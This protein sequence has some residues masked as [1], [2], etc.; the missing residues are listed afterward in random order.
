MTRSGLTR[1]SPAMM[2]G[3][4]LALRRASHSPRKL[5]S[6]TDWSEKS[7]AD[8]RF[9]A[10]KV[11]SATGCWRARQQRQENGGLVRV[12]DVMPAD[13]YIVERPCRRSRAC[14]RTRLHL[15]CNAPTTSR[16]CEANAQTSLRRRLQFEAAAKLAG[17]F[18]N[19]GQT[20]SMSCLLLVEP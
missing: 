1:R 13:I 19:D 18:L 7:W 9:R 15:I 20:E 17:K 10:R 5:S 14:S 11:A 8:H 12:G 6:R 16:P 4:D 2:I 3:A